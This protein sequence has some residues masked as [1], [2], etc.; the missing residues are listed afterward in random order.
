MKDG[1][2]YL[3]TNEQWSL[4]H[5]DGTVLAPEITATLCMDFETNAKFVWF[6]VPDIT[7][8]DCSEMLLLNKI[9]EILD[10]PRTKVGVI[11]GFE[12]EQT[13]G[14]DLTFTGRITFYSEKPVRPEWKEQ[15]IREAQRVG[16]H[17]TFRSID[18]RDMRNKLEKPLA[19]NSHDS[20]D[21]DL[22][23]GRLAIQL[24]KFMCPVWY[25]D[26]SLKV[27]DSLRES[28]EA[29]LKEC[30]KCVL[31]LTPNFLSNE[32][33]TK[34]E[35]DSVFTREVVEKQ[36]LILPVWHDVSRDDV[37]RYSMILADRVAAQWSLGVEEVARRLVRALN[38]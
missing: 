13:H 14:T 2:N 36:K 16:H 27:G 28:I 33:W 11:G 31:I 34:R 4:K 35:Y 3:R 8:V 24:Q 17:L 25:D 15:M 9:E 26:F 37:Y 21:K 38:G 5:A 30:P 6:Y 1:S 7:G 20:R 29:G 22:I 18:Y 19:F 32:G 23:A 10:W 12:G